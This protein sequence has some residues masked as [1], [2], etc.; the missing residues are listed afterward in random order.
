MD[1][2]LDLKELGARL[3]KVDILLMSLLQRRMELAFQVGTYKM[4]KGLP[5]IRLKVEKER[6]A[7]I[8][9][10]AR[11]HKMNPHFVN[12][13]LYLVIGESCKQ[14]LIQLQSTSK[15]KL[16]DP[17]NDDQWYQILKRNLLKL[18]QR[19][20]RTYDNNYDTAYF[21]T[22]SYLKFEEALLHEEIRQ[23]SEKDTILDLGCATGRMTIQLAGMFRRAVGY[24]ISAHMIRKA[25]T[26]IRSGSRKFSH[27]S[28]KQA[29]VEEGIPE[30]SNSAS[31]VV[32]NLGTASDFRN[33]AG[34]LKEVG[35]V[36]KPGG[37]FFFS[38]YNQDALIYRWD[39]M[40]WP[41]G[42]AAE[43]NIHKHCLDVHSGNSVFSIYARPYTVEEVTKL[44]QDGIT[45]AKVCMHPTISS[46]LPSDLFEDQAAVQKSVGLIDGQLA[47]ANMGAYIIVTGSKS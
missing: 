43:I 47:E 30:A 18:T 25:K 35:R 23:L 41:V 34:V 26:K 21:A 38:F 5:F 12:S 36:L 19:W 33:I 45:V 3:A 11:K 29:D 39:F 10:W 17:E 32:M 1:L 14:Q 6:L 46:I 13:I 7:K 2:D 37:R 20:A 40:P 28:F 27:V 24:D 9:Q 4:K 15:R 22:H 42:L 31:L 8:R 44:F 16:K